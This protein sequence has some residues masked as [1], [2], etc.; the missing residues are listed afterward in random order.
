MSV[1]GG[2]LRA[3]PITSRTSYSILPVP[4]RRL[5]ENEHDREDEHN[6]EITEEDGSR[7]DQACDGEPRDLL[8]DTEANQAQ[9]N[10]TWQGEALNISIPRQ[11]S[12]QPLLGPF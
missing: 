3:G 6:E 12:E 7:E 1:V 8:P 4:F 2:N 9:A 5:F 10:D 11:H